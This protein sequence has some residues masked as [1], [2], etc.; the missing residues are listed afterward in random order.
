MS[1]MEPRPLRV[2]LEPGYDGGRVGAW[3]LDVPGLFAWAP[4]RDRA[5][6][7]ALSA[8]G[9][10]REWLEERGDSLDLPPIHWA[11]IVEE[12]DAVPG[13]EGEAKATFAEDRR[14]V[15]VEEVERILRRLT[16]ARGDL[17]ALAERV[18]AFEATHGPLPTTGGA[19]E[20]RTADAVLRHVAG[21]EVMLASRLDPGPRFQAPP[22]DDVGE[23]LSSSRG[24]V[25]ARVRDL[26]AS[27]P[28]AET[29][30]RKGETWT[31]AK[32]LRRLLYHSMDHLWELDRRLARADGSA[33]RVVVTTERR[34]AV[35]DAVRVLRS[36][37]WDIRAEDP[38][39]LEQAI[40]GSTEVATAWDGSRLVGMARSMSDGALNALI[41]TVVVHPRWQALGIGHRV[42]RALVDDR[43][44]I[45]FS[46]SAA[47]G[48]DA[49]YGHLGFERDHRAMVRRRQG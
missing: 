23:L 45:R 41:A 18:T 31:L 1:D 34:P 30:D 17:L 21:A 47:S 5:L 39:A 40:A 49:W 37:G 48:L 43:P 19:R 10:F 32:V 13:P 2:W 16:M 6:S 11:E 3:M 15:P 44:G 28:A 38:D 4:T 35:E 22:G 12:V 7:N 27:V 26:H 33:D 42:M 14:R 25:T 20:E 24:W 36:V 9:R 8:A 29:V 46:L